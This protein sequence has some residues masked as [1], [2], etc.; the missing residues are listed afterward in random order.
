MDDANLNEVLR[1]TSN[2]QFWLKP[3]G[4]SKFPEHPSAQPGTQ[5]FADPKLEIAFAKTKNPPPV[6]ERDIFLVYHIKMPHME[7]PSLVCVTE[8]G[9]APSYTTLEQ[10]RNEEWRK[11]YPWSIYAR[12]LTPTFGS[13]WSNYSLNP[14]SLAKEYNACNPS[15]KVMLGAI[16]FGATKLRIREDF[17]KFLL[18]EIIGLR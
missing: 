7:A 18:N 6:Q 9:T 11:K 17:A 4:S 16:N 13:K 5:F 3:W 10:I 15:D 8:A 12:N 14:F 2:R 1:D